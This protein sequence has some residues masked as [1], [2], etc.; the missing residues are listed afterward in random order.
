MAE[1]LASKAGNVH[2]E[3]AFEDVSWLDFV[4]SAV[5]IGPLLERAGELGVGNT[6]LACVCATKDAVGSNTNLGIILLLAPLCAVPSG[7]KLAPG[8]ED[9]LEGLDQGDTEMVYEA[10]RLAEPGGLG[11][12]DAADVRDPPPFGLIEAMGRAA[13]QD[14]VAR[15][16]VNGFSDVIGEISPSLTQRDL[17]MDQLIVRTHLQ[18]MARE[19]DSLIRRKCGDAI[20]RESASHAQAAL[21]AGWP[22][23]QSGQAMFDELDAW[24][25]GDGHRRNPG[26]SADLVTAGLFVALREGW[27]RQPFEWSLPL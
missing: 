26:T 23:S 2:S 18:Q 25:R 16:Y 24:L 21:D 27:V 15:Q 14:T 5:I 7:I 19:P 12:V 4:T 22:F 8:I 20:A 10:I 3:A 9:V 11:T 17:P 1:V 6:V 13:D